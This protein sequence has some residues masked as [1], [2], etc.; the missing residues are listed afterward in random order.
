MEKIS[1]DFQS[2]FEIEGEF[3]LPSDK[4]KKITGILTVNQKQSIQLKLIG[5]SFFNI[6]RLFQHHKPIDIINGLTINGKPLTL[7]ECNV[8]KQN[9]SFPGSAITVFRIRYLFIGI[10]IEEK[11]KLKF[12]MLSI[13]FKH[14]DKWLSIS[15]IK[16]ILSNDFKKVN[17]IYEQPTP[18]D[19]KINDKIKA[20]FDFESIYPIE[21]R[22]Q[23]K[24]Q[25]EQYVTLTFETND[26]EE[27]DYDELLNFAYAFQSFLSITVYKV[28]YPLD[29]TFY[30]Q[31]Y[32]TEFEGKKI[33]KPINLFYSRKSVRI[34][35]KELED[36][37]ILIMYK[38]IKEDFDKIISNWYELQKKLHPIP[39][40]INKYFSNEG[41]FN[42]NLFLYITKSLEVFHREFVAKG[43]KF[44]KRLNDLL[45]EYSL[46]ILN[47]LVKDKETFS[48]LV[49]NSRNYY[50]H[51]STVKGGF[52]R[53]VELYYLTEK[54][55][56]LL[57]I[58]ILHKT[59]L[60]KEWIE[61]LLKKKKSIFSYIKNKE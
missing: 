16:T 5:G 44:N 14:L 34:E 28:S 40:L 32:F 4:Q 48:Q 36:E 35:S 54:L 53:G 1:I 22:Y 7:L 24:A 18:I 52:A 25:I 56:L 58:C 20:T 39:N 13:K 3:W 11:P 6:E 37:D 12:N 9:L 59:G 47:D 51:Y 60:S 8:I 61:N 55:K 31:N 57:T 10:N 30:S 43:S 45:N 17:I 50:T 29:F 33:K 26:N 21:M 46:G 41:I 49:T 19:F 27:I 23:K 38:D 15:G 42:E 2:N